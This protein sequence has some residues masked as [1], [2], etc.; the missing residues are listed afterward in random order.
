MMGSLQDKLSNCNLKSKATLQ[1]EIDQ[2]WAEL[3]AMEVKLYEDIEDESTSFGFI[4]S[5]SMHDFVKE[6]QSVFVQVQDTI[7]VFANHLESHIKDYVVESFTGNEETLTW[8]YIMS[9]W[10]FQREI[11]NDRE[12]VLQNR[13]R[14]SIKSLIDI[15][16]EYVKM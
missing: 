4:I 14:C 1:K 3:I 15:Y 8:T 9:I 12:F 16:R 13:G 10:K 7:K 6:A 11:L 2:A 5:D